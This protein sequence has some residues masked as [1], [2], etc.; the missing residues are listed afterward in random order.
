MS[1]QTNAEDKNLSVGAK[2]SVLVLTICGLVGG[3]MIALTGGFYHESYRRS[4]LYTFV[5]GEAAVVMAVIHLAISALGVVTLL[6]DA[7]FSRTTCML[8]ALSV[9]VPPVTIG[10]SFTA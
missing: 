10:L 4:G 9:V 5:S 8:A 6:K 3:W 7:G 1:V 2:L